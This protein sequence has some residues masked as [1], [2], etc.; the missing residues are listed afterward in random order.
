MIIAIDPGLSGTGVACFNEGDIKS[1]GVRNFY[2]S[3]AHTWWDNGLQITSAVNKFITDKWLYSTNSDYTVIIEE[4]EFHQSGKGLASTGSGDT[5]KLATLVGML[6]QS[7]DGIDTGPVTFK[8]VSPKE[9]KGQLPKDIVIE[10]IK[11][12]YASQGIAAPDIQS[13]SWDAVGIG[14][15]HMGLLNKQG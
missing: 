10:R 8:L 11:A 4:P 3:K 7:I 2:Y 13:H 15:W 12:V 9:W 5:F 6:V 1:L 14:L